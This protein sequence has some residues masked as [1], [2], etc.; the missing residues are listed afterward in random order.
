MNSVDIKISEF[1]K[2]PFGRYYND[3]KYSAQ[4][5]RENHLIPLLKKYDLVNVELDDVL[6]YGGSFLEEV[7]GGL[8]RAGY[9]KE[10]LDS[11]INLISKDNHYIL[12]IKK[13]INE[14]RCG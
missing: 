3:G 10:L 7:F 2:T 9:S 12:L 4:E 6:G 8:V 14:A 13:Y 5:F 11:S 1:S